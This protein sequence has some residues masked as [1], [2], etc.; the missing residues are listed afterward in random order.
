MT[1]RIG[2]HGEHRD[3]ISKM[4]R[5]GESAPRG[6]EIQIDESTFF[7]NKKL[8]LRPSRYTNRMYI[9]QKMPL[10]STLGNHTCVQKRSLPGVIV[11]I[12]RDYPSV[13][14]TLECSICLVV[15]NFD[16]TS[17]A[18]TPTRRKCHVCGRTNSTTGRLK[19]FMQ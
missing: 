3:D 10:S 13:T 17:S 12:S 1:Q 14:L 7:I 5:R 6:I 11:E 16:P 8:S 18:T 2:A 15:T 19:T 4:G 9:L